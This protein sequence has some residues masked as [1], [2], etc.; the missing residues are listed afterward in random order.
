MS[1]LRLWLL[2]RGL[3]A[4]VSVLA[5][6]AWVAP[7]H[8]VD[9]DNAEFATLGVFGG[10]AH[11]SGYP[12]E[13]LWL[14]ATAWLP[15]T[16][17]AHTTALATA[18]L[19]ALTAFVLYSAARA[20]GATP[21][22]AT[23]AVVLLAGSPVLLRIGT[24]AEVFSLNNL[25]VASILLFSAHRAPARGHTRATL[26]GV[27]AGLGLSNHLTCALLGPVGLLGVVRGARESERPAV[28]LFLASGGL[29]VGLLPYAYLLAAPDSPMSWGAPRDLEQLVHLVLRRD[30]GGPF[31]FRSAGE[32]VGAWTSLAAFL[33]TFARA[34]LWLPLL[35]TSAG[36]AK[37]SRLAEA[38]ETRAAWI[39]L[40][41]TWLIA[42]PLLVLRFDVP[43]HGIGLYVCQRFYVLPIVLAT[44]P[45]AVGLSRLFVIPVRC[46][47][48][49]S[50]AIA[51]VGL[52]A[53]ASPSLPYLSRIHSPAVERSAHNLLGSMPEGAV[54]I[55]GQ[56]ELHAATGYVQWALGERQDVVVVTWPLI[57]LQWYRER[58][59]ARGL[60]FAT[61][62]AAVVAFASR[63]L[64]AGRPVF[65]DRL[66]RE[67]I[68]AF[69]TYPHG[70][71]I[72]VLP[73]GQALPSVQ[74]VF[75]IN[76]ALYDHFDLAYPRPGAN[77]EF[78][79][80]VHLRY[81]AIWKMIE[82]KLVEI[83]ETDRAARARAM[84]DR[85]E[86]RP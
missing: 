3:L 25:V 35:L 63:A 56:D 23:S 62:P 7:V 21:L 66:Q 40:G 69:P 26:L 68:S 6:Y 28:S 42:G 44:I 27:I 51:T 41:A 65:V 47:H 85:L 64:A 37:R 8:I 60:A 9:G 50:A 10:A 29:L 75:E 57:G 15:G 12:L 5:L 22:A 82:H 48:I 86:P 2:D 24:E 39:A 14:R 72:R 71:L 34:W 84:A 49:L 77:D 36:F 17:P 76:S 19:C 1:C 38:Q 45:V 61:E 53:T 32:H 78:A 16:T 79:T 81:S 13:V 55:H 52:A 83:G 4:A 80:E 59:A 31:A 73:R 33:A 43:P 74:E 46:E 70:V 58:I 18:L 11:P 20:W 67:V 30:Y 54:V